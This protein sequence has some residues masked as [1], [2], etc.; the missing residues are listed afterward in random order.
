MDTKDFISVHRI[1]ETNAGLAPHRTDYLPRIFKL[2]LEGLA[3][4]VLLVVIMVL[5]AALAANS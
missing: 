1:A 2:L 4:I 5:A 3:P